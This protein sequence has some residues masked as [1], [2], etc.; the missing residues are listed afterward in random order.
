MSCGD[1]MTAGLPVSVRVTIALSATSLPVPA[2]V[3]IAI[4]GGIACVIFSSPPRA[5][6]YSASGSEWVV[7]RR[8]SLAT[9]MGAPP[10]TPTT[11][12]ACASV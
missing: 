1:A 5:S 9:S 12:S 7:V 11:M 2:V 6:S 4:I 3:G 10:P 8:T